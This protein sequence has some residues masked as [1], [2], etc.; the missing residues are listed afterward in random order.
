MTSDMTSDIDAAADRLQR[1]TPPDF[2][3]VSR[4]A[5]AIEAHCQEAA[6][7]AP[8]RILGEGYFSMAVATASGFV[9]RL[10]TSPDVFARYQKEW[11]VLPWL[12]AHRL[13]ARV[14]AHRWLIEPSA[15]FPF[16]G[17]GYP[18]IEGRTMTQQDADGPMA[19]AL[20]EQIA[21]F[22]LAV[23]C[24]PTAE[25]F[26]L[27]VPDGREVNRQWHLTDR[28]VSLLALRDVLGA[29]EVAVVDSWWR[30]FLEYFEA[31]Q[32]VPTITH[33]DIGD[34]NL[35]VDAPGTHLVG[36]IDW[37]HCAVGDPLDDFTGLRYLGND[38]L[39]LTLEA[40]SGLGRD[41]GLGP[42]GYVELGVAAQ[43][44]S[45]DPTSVAARRAHRH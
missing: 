23:H 43:R 32:Y 28:D 26:G 27:G 9:F 40:Y 1:W 30:G 19:Q 22:N 11:S 34:E 42:R 3:D 8:L 12:A 25:A 10:G 4:L 21:A 18:L 44:L 20:A 38:F 16:G 7:V 29:T 13:P 17:I 41:A 24:L 45:S 31:R 2:S 37:E 15:D 39:R 35:L 36:V 6:P 14:P 33:A 5:A